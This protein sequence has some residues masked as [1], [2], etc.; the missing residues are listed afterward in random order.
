MKGHISA[1]ALGDARKLRVS[2]MVEEIL[3]QKNLRQTI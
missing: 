3:G 2:N 1:N